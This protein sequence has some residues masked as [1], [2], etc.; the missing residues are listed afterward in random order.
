[1]TSSQKNKTKSIEQIQF[2]FLFIRER[3]SV[4]AKENEMKF[5]CL[6]LVVL[7]SLVLGSALSGDEVIL[8]KEQDSELSAQEV[9]EVQE[10]QEAQADSAGDNILP[11]VLS[12]FVTSLLQRKK[13]P[14]YMSRSMFDEIE[15][16]SPLSLIS[17]TS[18]NDPHRAVS[19]PNT[20]DGSSP[21]SDID[22]KEK[23]QIATQEFSQEISIEPS[24]SIDLP[25]VI[26]APISRKESKV[27][28]TPTP[29]STPM[30]SPLP[31]LQ[32]TVTPSSVGTNTGG[33][34][35]LDIQVSASPLVEPAIVQNESDTQIKDSE[36]QS[37]TYLQ[38]VP[39]MYRSC[40]QES[41]RIC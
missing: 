34:I 7:L 14:R 20:P 8:V 27:L 21:C 9:Q 39:N 22:D 10:V 1:M 2:F 3:A 32:E 5:W 25:V 41:S 29:T 4:T 16:T 6:L 23:K 13:T 33:A 30:Y 38:I 31:S 18:N 40:Y 17:A 35:E 28:A 36:E 37:I 11:E 15:P 26:E 19:I 12:E 24:M